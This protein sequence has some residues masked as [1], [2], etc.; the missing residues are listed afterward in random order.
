VNTWGGVTRCHCSR[1]HRTFAT[2]TVFDRHQIGSRCV[3][4]TAIHARLSE[5][6][7]FDLTGPEPA[8][9]FG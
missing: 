1:C 5:G 7:W 2:I 6:I 9:L 8:A 4:P 3:D